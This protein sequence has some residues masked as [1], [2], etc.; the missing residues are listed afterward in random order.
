MRTSSNPSLIGAFIDPI[1][2][3][4][5]HTKF[6]MLTLSVYFHVIGQDGASLKRSF[7]I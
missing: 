1:L 3:A 2:L 6:L 7:R 5:I 4:Y